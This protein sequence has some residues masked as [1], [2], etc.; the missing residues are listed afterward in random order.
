MT[1]EMTEVYPLAKVNKV[2]H[3]DPRRSRQKL[4]LEWSRRHN[5]YFAKYEED[6]TKMTEI[7]T[8]IQKMIE[9]LKAPASTRTT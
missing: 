3:F 9:L 1:A 4:E 5:R 2:R 8:K 6:M 7:A